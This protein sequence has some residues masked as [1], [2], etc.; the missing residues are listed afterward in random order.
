MIIEA[1]DAQLAERDASDLKW[2][3]KH[4]FCDKCGWQIQDEYYYDVDGEILCEECIKDKYRRSTF[5]YISEH[6]YD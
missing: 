2:E 5:E 3:Q 4:P 6:W 1:F